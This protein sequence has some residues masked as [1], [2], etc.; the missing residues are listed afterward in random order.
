MYTQMPGAYLSH[1]GNL[2]W[3]RHPE[4]CDTDEILAFDTV[5]ETFRRI[6]RPPSRDQ[7]DEKLFLV[8][9]HGA[10]AVTAILHGS[11]DLWVLEDYNSDSS[12]T[13][14]R[15]DL[16]PPLLYA[17]WAMNVSV[18]GHN[19]ILLQ[20]DRV[21]VLYGLTGK[22]VLKQINLANDSND[23]NTRP[24]SFVFRDSL[25][26]RGMPSSIYKTPTHKSLTTGPPPTLKLIVQSF[27]QLTIRLLHLYL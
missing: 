18:L 17:S 4:V 6:P 27:S 2:H 16:P 8:E 13:P 14:L 21:V 19:V 20:G 22:K 12:W 15:V 25:E 7:D 11:L 1:R 9:A 10:L 24:T 26:R 3:L 23:I 5:V